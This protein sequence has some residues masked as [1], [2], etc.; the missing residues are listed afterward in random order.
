MQIFNDNQVHIFHGT[1][2]TTV[3]PSKLFLK[4]HWKYKF[5]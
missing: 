5:I 1:K 2:D 4:N 3:D